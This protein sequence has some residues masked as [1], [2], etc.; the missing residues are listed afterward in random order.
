VGITRTSFVHLIADRR[1]L[2][3]G[4]VAKKIPST[5][6]SRPNLDH[7][8]SQAKSL[9]ADLREGKASAVKTFI[10]CLPAAKK[11]TPAAVRKAGF[12]LADAHSAIARKSGFANWP[13]LA[14]HVEQ[15]RALEGEW[16]FD[17]LEVDGSQMPPMSHVAARLLIDG[18]R[19]RMESSEASYEGVFNIDVEE[20]PSQIDIEFVEGPEAG[21]WSYGI[22]RFDGKELVFCLGLTGSTRPK[23]FATAKGTGHALERLTRVSS[24]RPVSVTGGTRSPV[25]VSAFAHRKT[26]LLDRLQGKWLP[27]SLV[28]SGSPLGPD[29]LSYV[30]RAQTANETKVVAGGQTMVH[31]LMRLDESASPVSIDYLNIGRGSKTVTLGILD[32][33][34]DD[35]RVCMAKPGDPRPNDFTCVAKSGRT[36]SRWTK[37]QA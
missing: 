19:F 29:M 27:V 32:W 37:A 31:A 15:L 26:P 2:H 35:M 5:L 12:R 28:S 6:P 25:D 7:L 3:G 4:P 36:L 1:A 21:N 16:A 20:N 33:L 11:M 9:L 14:R 23:K 17:S 24:T 10:E 22:F 13:G 8:R 30:S 34:G 18:D